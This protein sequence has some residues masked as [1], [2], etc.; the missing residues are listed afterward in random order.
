LR[1]LEAVEEVV[2]EGA[3]EVDLQ[4]RDDGGGEA[5]GVFEAA[6][7]AFRTS[8]DVDEGEGTTY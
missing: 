3:V 5:E 4:P 6:W 1:A 8:F 2:R 7:G